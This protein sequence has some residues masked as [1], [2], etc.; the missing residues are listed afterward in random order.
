VVRTGYCV[1]GT[2]NFG[3]LQKEKKGHWYS[4]KEPKR[5]W[6]LGEALG[7]AALGFVWMY[8]CCLLAVPVRALTRIKAK[9]NMTLKDGSKGGTHGHAATFRDICGKVRPGDGLDWHHLIHSDKTLG[10]QTRPSTSLSLATPA[11]TF[12]P[13]SHQ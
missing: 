9:S 7:R 10:G 8:S 5:S 4:I 13:T 12:L 6:G 11:D 1:H 3:R 2:S